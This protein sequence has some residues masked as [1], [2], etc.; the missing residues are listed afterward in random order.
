MTTFTS[1]NSTCICVTFLPVSIPQANRDTLTIS[2]ARQRLLT[3]I[4]VF[5][6]N[7]DPAV[8]VVDNRLAPP[9]GSN[10]M[11]LPRV[12]VGAL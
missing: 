9:F 6:W 2:M 8:H 7:D 1:A 10:P 4:G 5:S 3:R 12:Q 11:D